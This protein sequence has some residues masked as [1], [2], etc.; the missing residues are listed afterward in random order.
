MRKNAAILIKI[1]EALRKKNGNLNWW[2]GKTQFEIIVGAILTQN[3]SWSNVEKAIANLKK[4]GLLDYNSILKIPANKLAGLIRPS[5]YYN[6]K[7]KKLK[8][9]V[10]FIRENFDENISKM[11]KLDLRELR[12]K[13]LEI[14]GI[15]NE[16]AD[17]IILYAFN[18]PIFV[19]DTYTNRVF[20]RIGLIKVGLTYC[21]VQKFFMDNLPS[22]Y[23]LYNDFHAQIVILGKHFCK[24]SPVCSI[25]P[26]IY[27]CDYGKQVKK[28]ANRKTP[29][30]GK[31]N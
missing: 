24:K 4:E 7:A 14:N 31:N 16:T 18:K 15:G 22:D 13:L 28:A 5:G 26:V 11:K 25:C 12:L 3:T 2:P 20:T 8:N 10:N 6:Q 29:Q 21:E 30:K 27:I 1:Y 17:S 9:F 19:V 23:I